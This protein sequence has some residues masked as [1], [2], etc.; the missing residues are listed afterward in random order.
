MA[1]VRRL[2]RRY[3]WNIKTVVYVLTSDRHASEFVIVGPVRYFT[4]RALV[5]ASRHLSEEEVDRVVS[6]VV[7][8]DARC[9]R[10]GYR[11]TYI[12]AV[13]KDGEP[14]LS[15][16]VCDNCDPS[17]RCTLSAYE[18]FDIVF[19]ETRGN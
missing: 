18:A 10:C 3:E 12:K 13:V 15:T 6:K 14:D 17:A 1:Q 2:V 9:R 16:A 5:V 11:G 4:R 8:S 19:V 7:F